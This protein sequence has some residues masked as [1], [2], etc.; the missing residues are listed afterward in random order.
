MTRGAWFVFGIA[1]A[2]LAGFLWLGYAVGT[3]Q[4]LALDTAIRE[5]VHSWASPALTWLM[6][7]VTR[8]GTT[9]FLAAVTIAAWWALFRIGHWRAAVLLAVSTLGMMA[10]S[11][12]LK[13]EYH[14]VRPPAYFAYDEPTNYSYPSGHAD[15]SISFYGLLAW[16]ATRYIPSRAGRRAAWAA[17]AM[18]VLA[19]GFSRV[20][21]GVHY[22]SDVLGGYALG[23][24][25]LSALIG[26]HRRLRH[27]AIAG[28][29]FRLS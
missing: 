6:L 4:P 8:L 13:V 14:R 18:L 3:G 16:I 26:I 27:A 1:A 11:E 17:A 20:Y 7:G 28:K 21:L 2:A 29:W 10:L 12:S 23:L 19:I 9:R 5:T 24:V 25:Y 22:P 15:T